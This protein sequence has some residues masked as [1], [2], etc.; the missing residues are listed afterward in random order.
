MLN[1]KHVVCVV[2]IIILMSNLYYFKRNGKKIEPLILG[3]L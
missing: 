1:L 2:F 3:V